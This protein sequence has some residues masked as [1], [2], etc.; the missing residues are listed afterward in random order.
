[1]SESPVE[2]KQGVIRSVV[3]L[4]WAAA[5]CGAFLYVYVGALVTYVHEVAERFPFLE[6]IIEWLNWAT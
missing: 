6:R 1:M 4:A 2:R 3:C 5:V